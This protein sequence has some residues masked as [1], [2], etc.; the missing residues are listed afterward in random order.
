[1]LIRVKTAYGTFWKQTELSELIR[2][3]DSYRGKPSPRIVREL[4]EKYGDTEEYV[5]SLF[6]TRRFRKG[7]KWRTLASL[8]AAHDR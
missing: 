2:E 5:W 7:K 6:R 1:L 4:A 3:V 8:L